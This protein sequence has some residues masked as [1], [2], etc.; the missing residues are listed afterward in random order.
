MVRFIMIIT[1]SYYDIVFTVSVIRI[2]PKLL[3]AH[4]HFSQD[5]TYDLCSRPVGFLFP[6][7]H[8]TFHAG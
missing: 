6:K 4:F 2:V 8:H 5:P 1:N 3:D 7:S